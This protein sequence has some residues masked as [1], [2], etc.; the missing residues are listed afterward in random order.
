[1]G[2]IIAGEGVTGKPVSLKEKKNNQEA[3]ILVGV[4]KNCCH[5]VE[6]LDFL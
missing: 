2:E 5:T 1:M 4:N 6:G 3:Q